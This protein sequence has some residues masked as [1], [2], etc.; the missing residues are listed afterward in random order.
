MP[1]LTNQQVLQIAI[2]ALQ[3]RELTYDER[4]GLSARFVEQSAARAS[5]P[6]YWIVSYVS[7]PSLLDSRDYFIHI[8]DDTGEVQYILGPH[9]RL[10]EPVKQ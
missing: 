1:S 4:E 7:R 3:M 9:G 6:S 5:F 8:Q 10:R 2:Q